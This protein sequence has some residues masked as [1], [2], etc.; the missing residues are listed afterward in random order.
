MEKVQVI[1]V[2]PGIKTIGE[3]RE[4]RFRLAEISRAI[5]PVRQSNSQSFK[6]AVDVV[7]GLNN[8]IS[9]LFS[10][11]MAL[12]RVA[13]ASLFAFLLLAPVAGSVSMSELLT[14]EYMSAGLLCL[15]MLAGFLTRPLSYTGASWFG[16]GFVLSAL[17]GSP[18]VTQGALMLLSLIFAV[19]GPGLYSADQLI[20]RGLFSMHRKIHKRRKA[21]MTRTE[22]DYRAFSQIDQRVK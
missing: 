4:G 17:A 9:S 12:L 18:D 20:R 10:A 13:C 14:T 3:L 8:N 16:Y 15:S 7:S 1:S 11:K 19:L 21:S 5:A 2:N 6:K 22:L